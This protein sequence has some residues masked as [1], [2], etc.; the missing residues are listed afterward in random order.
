MTIC[1]ES[2]QRRPSYRAGLVASGPVIYPSSVLAWER[3]RIFDEG[4]RRL[5]ASRRWAK[6]ETN[7]FLLLQICD[8]FEQI[9]GMGISGRAKHPH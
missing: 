8:D 4:Q 7:S 9:A 3:E 6:L 5:A 2:L 1:V